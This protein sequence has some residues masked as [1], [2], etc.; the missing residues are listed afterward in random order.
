M[1]DTGD[2]GEQISE[3]LRNMTRDGETQSVVQ[4]A[5][6]ND[7]LSGAL[8]GALALGT[9]Y[10][11]R[12]IDI[13]LDSRIAGMQPRVSRTTSLR[14]VSDHAD[15]TTRAVASAGGIRIG[16]M[17]PWLAIAAAAW[18]IFAPKKA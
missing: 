1:D 10:L 18:F 3:R 5:D 14:P 16:D 11:S 17:L 9:S 6:R 8:Q 13:D 12:R 2:G 7:Y 4:V 15:L